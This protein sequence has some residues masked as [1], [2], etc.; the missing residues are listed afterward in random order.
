MK[1]I[2]IATTPSVLLL[3]FF[4]AGCNPDTQESTDQKYTVSQQTRLK[5]QAEY[6]TFNRDESLKQ[7]K[8]RLEIA[9]YDAQVSVI[10]GKAKA[11]V[12]RLIEDSVR[13]KSLLK[14]YDLGADGGTWSRTETGTTTSFSSGYGQ[15]MGY[16][17][18]K[19]SNGFTVCQ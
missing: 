14:K 11:E 1:K 15:G 4:L 3:S 8:S 2:L 9:R 7:A 18:C 5:L 16:T 10:E 6:S 13:D 19:Y 12:N 17:T